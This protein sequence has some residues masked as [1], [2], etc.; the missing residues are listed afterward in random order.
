MHEQL[1]NQ[2]DTNSQL[3]SANFD[4]F[5]DEDDCHLGYDGVEVT[6]LKSSS[7]DEGLSHDNEDID[8]NIVPS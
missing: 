5:S 8:E 7:D 2:C 6:N 1:E 3:S 4:L